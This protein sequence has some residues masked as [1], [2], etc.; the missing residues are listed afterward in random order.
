[1]RVAIAHEEALQAQ[2][3]G[4]VPGA[5][6]YDA[7]LD[8]PDETDAAQDEGTHDDFADVGLA[9]HQPAKVGALDPY[10]PA[11]RGRAARNQVLAI[12]EQIQLAGELT[13]ALH[14]EDVGL[15]MLI[16]IENFDA[17]LEHEEEIHAALAAREQD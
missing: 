3:I 15:A 16:E 7:A 9:D 2:R 13:F 10:H 1:M 8:V 17:A 11:V 12:V 6:Q 14:H 5:D 4:A